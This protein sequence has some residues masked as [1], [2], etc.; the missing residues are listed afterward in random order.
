MELPIETVDCLNLNARYNYSLQL[1]CGKP[2]P[3]FIMGQ[4][5]LGILTF[6]VHS[7]TVQS[8]DDVTNR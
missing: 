2:F 8:N 6:V 4:F 7:L 3:L 1:P 5:L